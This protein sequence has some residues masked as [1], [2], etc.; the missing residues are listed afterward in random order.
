MEGGPI[1]R[2]LY[3][4]ILIL[5]VMAFAT[6]PFVGPR[7]LQRSSSSWTPPDPPGP[8]KLPED[9]SLS[10]LP[11][12]RRTIWNPGIPGGIPQVRQVYTT[13]ANLPSGGTGDVGPAIQ[14]AIDAA[15]TVYQSTGI[16]QEVVLPAGTFRFEN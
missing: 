2:W 15:G 11:A 10:I 12:D 5:P 14:D 13:L 3:V 9:I 4:L 1:M 8:P 6:G 7:A 16:I